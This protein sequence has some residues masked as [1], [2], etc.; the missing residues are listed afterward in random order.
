MRQVSM[1]PWLV[2]L[3]I[4]GYVSWEELQALSQGTPACEDAL[5][6]QT[7]ILSHKVAQSQSEIPPRFAVRFGTRILVCGF[8]RVD[9]AS[10]GCFIE[11]DAS[12]KLVL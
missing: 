10:D 8:I 3:C 12:A 6:L 7:F 11:D 9:R 5:C 1:G 2:A 4:A